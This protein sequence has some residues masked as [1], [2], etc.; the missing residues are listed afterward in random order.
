MPANLLELDVLR[1]FVTGVELGSFA[2]AARR[3]GRSASAVSAQLKKLDE[4]LGVAVLR[5]AGRGMALTPAGEIL[6]GYARRML[7]LNDEAADAVRA[8]QLDGQV[9]VGVPEDFGERLLPDILGSFARARPQLRIEARVAR[10]VELVALLARG[11]LDL[12]L[13]W[14]NDARSPRSD[15]L[16]HL[17]MCWIAAAHHDLAAH[18]PLPLVLFEAPCLMRSAAVAALDRANRPWRSTFT[19]ASLGAIWAAVA[20]GLGIT[21]RTRAGMPG[22][23]RVLR[24]MPRLPTIGLVLH[25]A[26]AAPEPAVLQLGDIIASHVRPLIR[27]ARAT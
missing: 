17:P 18:R 15:D 23:L 25:Y 7:A 12:A 10:N 22:H 16:G 8:H 21:V 11:E 6:L 2:Q 1:T 20:A 19:S 27:T 5:K 24:G 3:V 9:R 26:H 4:Q 13:A 14:A